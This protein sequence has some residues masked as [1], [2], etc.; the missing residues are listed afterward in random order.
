MEF[1]LMTKVEKAQSAIL[2]VLNEEARPLGAARIHAALLAAGLDMQPRTIRFHLLQLDQRGL[3]EQIS[4]RA[5]R[6]ITRRGRE[7]LARSNVMDKVG[8]IAAKVD[9]L[10]YRMSL[11][12]PEARG[13]VVLNVSLLYPQNVN[14]ALNEMKLAFRHHLAIG[15]RLLL[16]RAGATIANSIV[17]ENYVA[18]GT[19]CSVTVSGVLMHAGIPVVSRFGGLLEI[20]DRKPTRFVELIEYSGSTLDP[21]E[22]FIQANMTRVRDAMNRGS[23]IICA[24]FREVPSIAVEDIRRLERT[25]KVAG[26]DGILEI[27]R[28]SQPLLGIPVAEGYSGMIVVG[29]LNPIAAMHEMGIAV[30]IRSLA[31]LEEFSTLQTIDDLQ[32]QNR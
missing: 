32:R 11:R 13:T 17:P 26:L 29:G 2:K 16:A 14:Q 30:K 10:G 12:L 22:V 6:A 3:T 25:M 23:G 7:E 21:L 24:G 27:G 18:I 9:T 15:S 31:G 5:G 19:V 8:V 28:P 20:R 4:R 1:G